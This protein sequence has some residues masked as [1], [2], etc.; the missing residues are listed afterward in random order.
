MATSDVLEKARRA[1]VCADTLEKAIGAMQ[2]AGLVDDRGV[3][4]ALMVMLGDRLRAHYPDDET[5]MKVAM[6]GLFDVANVAEQIIQEIEAK[7]RPN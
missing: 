6:F 5:R 4:S 7:D 3:L 2:D 1:A